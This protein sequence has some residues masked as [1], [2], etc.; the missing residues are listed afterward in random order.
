MSILVA[1]VAARGVSGGQRLASNAPEQAATAGRTPGSA[2]HQ[3]R[4]VRELYQL[5][6]G[7]AKQE[8]GQVTPSPRA[9]H[10]DVCVVGT[11]NVHDLTR[12]LSI[13]RALHL[14]VS[15]DAGI[16][17]LFRSVLRYRPRLPITR[18]APCESPTANSSLSYIGLTFPDAFLAA[19]CRI[20]LRGPHHQSRRTP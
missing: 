4:P 20:E 6:R 9:H 12:Y 1:C 14:M 2:N 15:L 7:A 8:G 17:Q 10:D 19:D 13:E 18:S 16:I 5:V 3:N 11:G